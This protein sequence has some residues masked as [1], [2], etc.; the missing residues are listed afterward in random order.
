MI[1]QA[2]EAALANGYVVAWPKAAIL[3]ASEIPG[4]RW[5][6]GQHLQSYRRRGTAPITAE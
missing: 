2:V 1:Y 6:I 4:R 3:L 5:R